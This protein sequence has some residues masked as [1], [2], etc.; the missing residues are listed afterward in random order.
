MKKRSVVKSS[1]ERKSKKN[2]LLNV[3]LIILF[4]LTVLFIVKMGFMNDAAKSPGFSLEEEIA[5]DVLRC[6]THADC[7]AYQL[8][9]NGIWVFASCQRCSATSHTCIAAGAGSTCDI[10]VF[11]YTCNGNIREDYQYDASCNNDGACNQ[12]NNRQLIASTDCS[13]WALPSQVDAQC[14]SGYVCAEP[15]PGDASCEINGYGDE[16]SCTLPD[17]SQGSCI[18][19]GGEEGSSIC[20]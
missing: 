9:G 17:G 20:G 6:K 4:I 13:Q 10:N 14:N 1:G 18:M 2:Y 7:G 5:S 16:T 12:K 15:T 11:E 8:N 3:V 19:N